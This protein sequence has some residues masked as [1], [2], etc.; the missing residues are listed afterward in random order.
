MMAFPQSSDAK[1][2][3]SKKRRAFLGI[4]LCIE[5][6]VLFGPATV[7]AIVYASMGFN[8][9]FQGFADFGLFS[10]RASYFPAAMG[11][12]ALIGITAL[13]SVVMSLLFPGFPFFS[14]RFA[15]VGMCSGVFTATL[16]LFWGMTSIT[17]DGF[18]AIFFFVCFGLPLVGTLHIAY[19]ARHLLFRSNRA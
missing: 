16:F 10:P 13:G 7:A 6:L 14:R 12:L 4:W 18:T 9:L 8:S 1:F 19:L 5:V 3:A 15:L 2:M 17:R 11:L